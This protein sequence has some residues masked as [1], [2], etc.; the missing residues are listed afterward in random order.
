MRSRRSGDEASDLPARSRFGEGRAETFYGSTSVFQCL[1]EIPFARRPITHNSK[2]P[3]SEAE[4]PDR[5]LRPYLPSTMITTQS[6]RGRRV[7]L[8]APPSVGTGAGKQGRG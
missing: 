5:L 6:L 3:H 1:E 2:R 7:S 8:P 4:E